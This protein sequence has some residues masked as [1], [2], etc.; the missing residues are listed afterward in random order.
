MKQKLLLKTMLLLCALIVGSGSVWAGDTTI[1][2]NIN[3]VNTATTSNNKVVNTTLNTSSISNGSGTWTAVT[4]VDSYAG[5]NSGAQLGSSSYPFNGTITLSGSSI[6]S[7]ATIKSIGMTLSSSAGSG[8]PYTVSAKVNNTTFGSNKTVY[9]SSADY[10]F[11]GS[12]TGNAIVLTFSCESNKNVII[13]KLTVTYASDPVINASSPVNYAADVTS[14]EIP[15]TI[16][17]PVSGKSL[18]ANSN[19]SWISNISVGASKVT[20]NM[21]ENTGEARTGKI[22]LSYE[23]ATSKDITINQA[24]AVTKYTV[25]IETPTNG[26]LVV[27]RAGVNVVSGSQIPDG[28]TLD[29]IVTPN[30]GYKKRNWQAVDA[31]THTYTSATATSYTINSHDVTFKANFDPLEQYTYTWNA[32]GAEVKSETLYEGDDVVFPEVNAPAGSGKVFFGWVTTSTVNPNEAPTLETTTNVKASANTTYYAVFADK[33]DATT[34]ATLTESE[35]K[36]N[37]TNVA[38]A[39]GDDPKSYTNNTNGITWSAKAYAAESAPWIQLRKNST[40][41]YLKISASED[42]SKVK[43][44]L[45]SSGTTGEDATVFSKNGNFNGKV[46]ILSSPTGD[47]TT[48]DLATS[49]TQNVLGD[50]TVTLSTTT[51]KDRKNIYVQTTA[52]ARIWGVEVT[53]GEITYSN[54]CTTISSYPISTL[55]NRSYGSY[56]TT[57][58]LDFSA[59]EGITAYIATG[60]N[61]AKTAIVLEEVDVVPANTPIIVKTATQ[62]AK[63]NVPVAT[64][65]ADD[66]STNKLVAGDGTT[67]WDGTAGY[68]YYF[69]KQDQFY[70]ATSGTLQSGKAYFKVLTSEVP[71]TT[72]PALGFDFGEGTTSIDAS[73]IDNGGMVNDNVIYDLSGRRVAQPTKGLYIV[74]GKK[75]IIK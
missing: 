54:Y 70:K 41:A 50:V 6:P 45:S 11:S 59:A 60:F 62:G 8:K 19:D 57:E 17:S 5:S 1:T 18:S 55:A 14:G 27:Q 52:G 13:T 75:V 73:L 12:V 36:S 64:V 16:S 21:T 15:Y 24:A 38:M 56:V 68:T 7:N 10:S 42:I 2:W 51:D 33:N 74:N 29:V 9:G 67:T 69:L 32:N 28:T 4:T 35:I 47:A 63:V 46:I 39:Y 48:G 37:F 23:G 34:K 66:V 53:C 61:Q 26:T 22:T 44:T 58:K 25:T 49:E 30:T 72:A 3:G 40:V 71:A 43:L 20:F 31:S 65:D